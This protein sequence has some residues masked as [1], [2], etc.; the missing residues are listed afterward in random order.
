MTCATCRWGEK[1]EGGSL[2]CT[3]NLFAHKY[4]PPQTVCNCQDSAG[5]HVPRWEPRT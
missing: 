4:N 2:Y 5:S 3:V 1:R